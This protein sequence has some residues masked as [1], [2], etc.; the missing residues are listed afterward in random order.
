MH[1]TFGTGESHYSLQGVS[2]GGERTTETSE[3]YWQQ[4]ED[5]LQATRTQNRPG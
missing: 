3:R 1:M 2:V 4:R 5:L